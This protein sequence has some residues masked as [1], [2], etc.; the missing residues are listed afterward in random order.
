[1]VAWQSKGLIF[2]LDHTAD[3]NI[4]GLQFQSAA[5]SERERLRHPHDITWFFIDEVDHMVITVDAWVMTEGDHR[6]RRT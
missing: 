2:F 1:M 5:V 4:A 6:R 3:R